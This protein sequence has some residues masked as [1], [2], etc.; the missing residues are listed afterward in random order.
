[1]VLILHTYTVSN[2]TQ[3]KNESGARTWTPPDGGGPAIGGGATA[4][5]G[6]A[7]AVAAEPSYPRVSC[8]SR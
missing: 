1:M 2:K 3:Q 7:P 5:G 8:A 4:I 6:A